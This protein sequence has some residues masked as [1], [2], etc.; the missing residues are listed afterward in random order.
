MN[1]MLDLV[2]DE[3]PLKTFAVCKRFGIR[4]E[5]RSI[6]RGGFKSNGFVWV[7]GTDKLWRCYKERETS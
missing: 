1:V 7:R 6:K 2:K 5:H 4:I 3:K